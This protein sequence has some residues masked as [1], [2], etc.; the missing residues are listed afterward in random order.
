MLDF[1]PNIKVDEQIQKLKNEL[2]NEKD[3]NTKLTN[4]LKNEKQNKIKLNDELNNYK[5]KYLNLSNLSNEL[6]I[7]KDK[8]IKLQNNINSYLKTVKELN[9]NIKKLESDIKSK[10]I[11]IENLTNRIGGLSL[12][13]DN[14]EHMNFY[15]CSIDETISF[16]VSCKNTDT[17]AKIEEEL[18]K[19]Y[20]EY[21]NDDTYFMVS[22]TKLKRFQTIQEN[23]LKKRDTI[24][25]NINE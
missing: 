15:I 3:K 10:N 5:Q 18:Y 12:N 4:E 23:N 8:N 24:I 16:P 9:I 25:L 7:E 20:P 17:F 6:K 21:K 11:I 22:G 13:S 14:S 1:I 2:K 19:E